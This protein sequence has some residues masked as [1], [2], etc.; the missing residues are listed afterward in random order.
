[1]RTYQATDISE[2]LAEPDI[3]L[4][5]L[6]EK[7]FIQHRRRSSRSV[8]VEQPEEHDERFGHLHPRKAFDDL[9]SY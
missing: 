4:R 9:I 6:E 5:C 8:D 7:P 2:S 3:A 1:M